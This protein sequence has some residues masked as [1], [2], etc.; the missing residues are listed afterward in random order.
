MGPSSTCRQHVDGGQTA[1]N[2]QLHDELDYTEDNGKL[3]MI[4]GVDWQP[5]GRWERCALN[6]NVLAHLVGFK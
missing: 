3:A 1:Q 2:D 4:E 5:T 6:V